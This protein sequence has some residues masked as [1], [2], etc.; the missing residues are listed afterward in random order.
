M[1]EQ[2]VLPFKEFV[3][4]VTYNIENNGETQPSGEILLD[5]E[6]FPVDY[7]CSDFSYSAYMTGNHDYALDTESE[8]IQYYDSNKTVVG[9]VLLNSDS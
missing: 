6:L 9:F 1:R 7:S 5:G 8:F 3:D 4:S 2:I